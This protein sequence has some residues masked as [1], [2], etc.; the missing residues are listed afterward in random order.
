MRSPDQQ[1]FET[2]RAPIEPF[3]SGFPGWSVAQLRAWHDQHLAAQTQI[4]FDQGH[5][6]VLDGQSAR[7]GRSVVVAAEIDEHEGMISDTVESKWEW[8]EWRIPF[9][10][11]SKFETIITLG[12]ELFPMLMEGQPIDEDGVYDLL[13]AVE[14]YV[15]RPPPEEAEDE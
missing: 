11:V 15:N 6:A 12:Q 13:G 3:T 9:G 14:E 7:D 10:H 4:D 5:F 2:T 8:H 1:E